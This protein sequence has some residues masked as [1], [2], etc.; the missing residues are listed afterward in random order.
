MHKEAEGAGGSAIESTISLH[1]QGDQSP[2]IQLV[3]TVPL[4]RGQYDIQAQPDTRAV[5][6]RIQMPDARGTWRA[7]SGRLRIDRTD[8]RGVVGRFYFKARDGQ[9]Q[10]IE[11]SGA[12]MTPS[13]R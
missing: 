13:I 6:A 7:E 12:F 5:A 8:E 10:S 1:S 9:N 4:H 11:V 2:T 3:A